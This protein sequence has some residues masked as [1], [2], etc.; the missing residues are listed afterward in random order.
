MTITNVKADVI[1]QDNNGLPADEY[2]NTFAF[3]IDGSSGL[4]EVLSEF[5]NNAATGGTN[6]LCYYMSECISRASDACVIKYYDVSTH[7]DGSAAGAPFEV[8]T[9]T[10]GAGGSAEPLP[11]Q[12]C[13]V[14]SFYDVLTAADITTGRHRGRIFLGPLNGS[15]Y[16]A[17]S[18][19]HAILHSDLLADI[20][21]NMAALQA[22]TPQWSTWSRAG[23]MMNPVIGGFCE[24]QFDVQRKRQLRATSR[25]TWTS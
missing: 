3:T 6:P 21:L 15:A 22:S 14:A 16:E 23:A 25:S 8:D 4:T 11:E 10:L 9:W 18:F 17:D 7:L 5:Y 13:A 2:T 12:I 20:S 24:Q 19:G 1:F